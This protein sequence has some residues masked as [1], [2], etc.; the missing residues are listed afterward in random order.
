MWESFVVWASDPRVS[1]VLSVAGVLL[2]VVGFGI[3]IF[4]VYRSR[5]AAEAA[6][7]AARS[8]RD[9]LG[10]FNTATECASAIQV[11]EEI[12]RLHRTGPFYLLPD[13]YTAARRSL[14]QIHHATTHLSDERR[15]KLQSAV[16]H[17]A[18]MKVG[19]EKYL[20]SDSSGET[21]SAFDSI[22]HN[23]IMAKQITELLVLL[24]ELRNS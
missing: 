6:A 20:A 24:V 2:S 7:Q 3:T 4:G 17:I 18:T 14:V 23:K 13:R 5:N 9:Q 19:V 12:E 16:T 15:S 1:G 11:L 8:V 22:K 21:D 10:R